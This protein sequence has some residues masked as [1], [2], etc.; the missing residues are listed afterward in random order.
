MTHLN[1]WPSQHAET[2]DF[3]PSFSLIFDKS[4][5]MRSSWPKIRS[6]V[7]KIKRD[8][9]ALL[10]SIAV[11]MAS[12]RKPLEYSSSIVAIG[13]NR[14]IKACFQRCACCRR[15]QRQGQV[16]YHFRRWGSK[17][18]RSSARLFWRILPYCKTIDLA[19]GFQ[20]AIH[21][22]FLPVKSR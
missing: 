11:P 21:N 13:P 8:M 18:R 19:N 3:N 1:S 15:Q 4:K 6:T 16:C 10:N 9:S 14:R 20:A 2:F 22:L 12:C 7:I 17:S 5:T